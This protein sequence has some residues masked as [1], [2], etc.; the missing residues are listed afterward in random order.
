MPVAV[1][2]AGVD[3]LALGGAAAQARQIGLGP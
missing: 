2:G 3:S 1:W